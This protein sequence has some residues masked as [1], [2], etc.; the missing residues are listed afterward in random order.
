MKTPPLPGQAERFLG[1][2]MIILGAG[3]VLDTSYQSS[4][5]GVTLAGLV[6]LGVGWLEHWRPPK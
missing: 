5:I 6:L 2:L 1:S 3:I 4:G